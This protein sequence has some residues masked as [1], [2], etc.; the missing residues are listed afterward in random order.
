M[1]SSALILE[2]TCR[3]VNHAHVLLLLHT[4]MLAM[5]IIVT[6][7]YALHLYSISC[8]A[9]VNGNPECFC[10]PGHNGPLC[11]SCSEGFFG[12]PPDMRCRP[13][14]C[15]GN[16][17]PDVP[18]SCYRETGLCLICINNSTGP[19][20]EA[21]A[22]GYYGDAITQNC[23]PCGCHT[24]GAIGSSCNSTG[25]CTCLIGVG[26]QRCDMCLVRKIFV[27]VVVFIVLCLSSAWLLE[28]H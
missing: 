26:G 4:S 22:D 1:V 20:C 3:T 14:D 10:R 21:C 8:R 12:S 13:C 23:Q 11:D 7:Y 16:I 5:F 17:D 6:C 25:Y 18:G 28:L 15:N 19:E 9:D 24:G 27:Q 2:L